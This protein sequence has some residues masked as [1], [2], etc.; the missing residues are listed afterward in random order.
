MNQQLLALL[1]VAAGICITGCAG[2]SSVTAK[3]LDCEEIQAP[4]LAE[5]E[6]R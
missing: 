1:G 3:L 5:V 2:N 6:L 4:K